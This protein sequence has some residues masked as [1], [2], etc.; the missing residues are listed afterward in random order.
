MAKREADRR[1]RLLSQKLASEE[2]TESALGQAEATA[3]SCTAAKANALY[4]Q[5]EIDVSIASVEVAQA[6]LERAYIKAP[7]GGRI[8]D[9]LRQPGELIGAEG[10][11]ELGRVDKMYAVAEVYETD[12]RRVKIGQ[13][14]TSHE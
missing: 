7:V 1:V 12:I 3:A 11:L 2:E 6:E 14:A 10:V 13:T 8:L 9:V 5:S 4:A